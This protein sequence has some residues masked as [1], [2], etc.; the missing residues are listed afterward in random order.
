MIFFNLILSYSNWRSRVASRTYKPRWM[1]YIVLG[2]LTEL[3]VIQK[4][5]KVGTYLHTK[6]Y[7][8]FNKKYK[9][10]KHAILGF[11]QILIL[12]KLI[13]IF[14]PFWVIYRNLKHH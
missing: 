6:L 4:Y 11:R 5:Y 1:E 13:R 14:F 10:F 12:I 8:L 7:K 3:Q 2:T 9:L